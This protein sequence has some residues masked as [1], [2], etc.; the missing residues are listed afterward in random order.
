[1]V[2]PV[3]QRKVVGSIVYSKAINV[4]TEAECQRLYGSKN[5]VKMVEGVVINVDQKSTKQRWK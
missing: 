4:M 3:D 1:M 2:Y 5:K